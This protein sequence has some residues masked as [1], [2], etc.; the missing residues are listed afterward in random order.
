M[1]HA[2]ESSTNAAKESRI[3]RW[4]WQPAVRFA[5]TPPRLLHWSG[6]QDYLQGQGP[7]NI[8]FRIVWIYYW[9]KSAMFPVLR[10]HDSYPVWWQVASPIPS[11]SA[12]SSTPQRVPSYPWSRL[13]AY[14]QERI[15]QSGVGGSG[16]YTFSLCW[17]VARWYLSCQH[18]DIHSFWFPRKTG[19]E[20]CGRRTGNIALLSQ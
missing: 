4:G 19:Y 17:Q 13:R 20:S 18:K 2:A 14:L 5:N 9:D 6:R 7:M 12:W 15:Y 8:L 1:L 16:N 11:P 3:H 10:P